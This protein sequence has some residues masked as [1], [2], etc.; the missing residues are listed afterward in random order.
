MKSVNLQRTTLPSTKRLWVSIITLLCIFT[1]STPFGFMIGNV[2][3]EIVIITISLFLNSKYDYVN[4]KD[5][6]L[7]LLF[8][9]IALIQLVVYPDRVLNWVRFIIMFYTLRNLFFYFLGKKYNIIPTIY[10]TLFYA[11][12]VSFS[13]Y[14]SVEIIKIPIPYISFDSEWMNVYN[15]FL[16]GIY[17]NVSELSGRQQLIELLG[18]SFKRN[19]GMF[20]EPGLLAVFLNILLF[21][22][23]FILKKKGKAEKIWLFL[24]LISTYSTTG[25]IVAIVQFSYW[26]YINSRSH[27]KLFL[28]LVIPIFMFLAIHSLLMEKQTNAEGSWIARTFD[29]VAGINLFFKSP[30]WGWGYGNLDAYRMFSASLFDERSCS[31][32]FITILYQ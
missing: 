14:I 23:L 24:M 10:K 8:T 17:T 15:L 4:F 22:N 1:T 16:G 31:N 13:I 25:F 11:L 18:Y 12:S 5:Y 9:L 19:Y 7:L 21:L 32:G 3:L 29:V 30:L 20:T 28:I 27:F 6:K 2:F 26:Y